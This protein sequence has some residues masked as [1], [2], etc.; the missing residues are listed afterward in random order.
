MAESQTK[1]EC[2]DIETFYE[3][4]DQIKQSKKRKTSKLTPYLDDEFHD[5][6]VNWLKSIAQSNLT[7]KEKALVREKKWRVV[8][9]LF[10]DDNKEVIPKKCLH[11]TL[12]EA[13]SS[14]AHRGRD[15]TD[16]YIRDR[17]AMISQDVIET[18][19]SICSIHEQQ[20]SVTSHC[21]RKIQHPIQSSAF[22]SHLELD[23]MDIRK[24]PCKCNKKHNWIFHAVDHHS[25]FS[26]LYPLYSKEAH[27]VV[28]TLKNL[29]WQFGFPAKLHTDNGAE[30][31]NQLMTTFCEKHRIKQVHGAP[32]KPST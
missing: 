16:K 14:I 18:F 24:I 19:V 25:K 11:K 22:M 3:H 26:W 8:E 15:K 1:R 29:C 23:L 7:K 31:K 13:H 4:L 30:F 32:R 28:E 27:E 12:S 2:V 5:E 10:T 17:Y 21:N 9:E 20:K 6:V